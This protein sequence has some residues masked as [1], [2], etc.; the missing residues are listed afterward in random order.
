MCVRNRS[1][2]VHPNVFPFVKAFEEVRDIVAV[3]GDED[4]VEMLRVRLRVMRLWL[5]C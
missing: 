1:V 4:A 2:D 3:E 5:R